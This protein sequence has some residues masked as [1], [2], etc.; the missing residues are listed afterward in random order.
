[1]STKR[2]T[3]YVNAEDGQDVSM[4]KSEEWLKQQGFTEKK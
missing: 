1:M 3:W 4:K 2:Y